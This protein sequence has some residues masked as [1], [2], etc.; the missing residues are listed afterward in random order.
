MWAL[1]A[2]GLSLYADPPDERRFGRA[3]LWA[4]AALLFGGLPIVLLAWR[5]ATRRAGAYDPNVSR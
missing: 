2:A 3:A 1:L 5:V 4:V